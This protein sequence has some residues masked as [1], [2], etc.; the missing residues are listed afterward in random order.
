MNLGTEARWSIVKFGLRSVSQD[1]NALQERKR[2][3]EVVAAK[4]D[5]VVDT[6]APG[7]LFRRFDVCRRAFVPR[8]AQV[9]AQVVQGVANEEIARLGGLAHRDA[10]S[11][12][13]TLRLRRFKLI[14]WGS[15][16]NKDV[17][18][19]NIFRR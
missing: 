7:L 6:A 8:V 12:L 1:G 17:R 18:T 2:L 5:S 11:L 14:K 13:L 4:G 9:G 15:V 16:G 3:N 19:R 10:E